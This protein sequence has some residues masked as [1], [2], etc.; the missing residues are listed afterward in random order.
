[1]NTPLQ[2]VAAM[3]VTAEFYSSLWK[4]AREKE[5]VT[6]DQLHMTKLHPHF[7]AETLVLEPTRTKLS[8]CYEQYSMDHKPISL[9]KTKPFN[10]A[11]SWTPCSKGWLHHVNVDFCQHWQCLSPNQ[12]YQATGN[13]LL[14]KDKSSYIS[15]TAVLSLS[16]KDLRLE[17]QG[18]TRWQTGL[19]FIQG[20][21]DTHHHC[22][23]DNTT[24]WALVSITQRFRNSSTY[25]HDLSYIHQKS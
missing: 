7:M 12:H 6:H 4:A 5:K 22:Q 11:N 3:P 23:T 24:D 17:R 20:S 19:F 14:L 18:A 10:T 21:T 15:N 2:G 1:M 9:S 16:S 8:W 13:K 25:F